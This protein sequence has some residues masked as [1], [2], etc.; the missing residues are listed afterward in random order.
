MTH[1]VTLQAILEN[2]DVTN[3]DTL[4]AILDNPGVTNSVTLQSNVIGYTWVTEDGNSQPCKINACKHL[5]CLL[6][7]I[8]FSLGAAR[9][10]AR[11]GQGTILAN[12]GTGDSS[13]IDNIH[14][15]IEM[16][17]KESSNNDKHNRSCVVG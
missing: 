6:L 11:L 15:F 12:F 9:K 14:P 3:S 16:H 2:P 7:V 10:T 8:A 13:N 17:A 4:Q 1:S 5:E